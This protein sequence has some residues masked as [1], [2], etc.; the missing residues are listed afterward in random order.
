MIPARTITFLLALIATAVAHGAT[1]RGRVIRVADGDTLTILDERS[2][3]R[4]VRIQGIDA[5]EAEQAFGGESKRALQRLVDGRTVSVE[6]GKTDRYGRLVGRVVAG[7][8]DVALSQVRAG[9]AWVFLEY[10]DESA[11]ADRVR[12]L[13]AER[14]AKDARRG[15]WSSASPV[16]PWRF[17]RDTR[18]T[19]P[20]RETAPLAA[21]A[22]VGNRRSGIYHLPECPDRDRVAPGN[23]V[24]FT[25]EAAARAAGYRKAGNCP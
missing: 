19:E 3:E 24:L 9:L 15:L 25:T 13:A 18:R 20:A 17:R 23:R 7:D 12:Y 4:R 22:I 1:I 6:T 10:L 2:V 11:P 14:E 16:P 5:P 21:D 8:A